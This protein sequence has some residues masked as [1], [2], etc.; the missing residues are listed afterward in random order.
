MNTF[1]VGLVSA[2][3]LIGARKHQHGL[4]PAAAPGHRAGQGEAGPMLAGNAADD[5][6]AQPVAQVRGVGPH[7]QRPLDAMAACR[8][9]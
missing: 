2:I 7:Y 9:S 8:A 1:L 3:S 5:G 4:Q 6:Q